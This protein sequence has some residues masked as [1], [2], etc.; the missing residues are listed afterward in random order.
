MSRGSE[1]LLT[2]K[3]TPKCEKFA[4]RRPYPNDP[5]HLSPNQS[6]IKGWWRQFSDAAENGR[7][8]LIS[9]PAAIDE[10]IEV[11][12]RP[13]FRD[14]ISP[15]DAD[16]L[17]NLLRRAELFNPAHIESICRDPSDDYL[18]ALAR[19]S[20]ADLLVTRDED[21]LVLKKHGKTEIV[22]VAEFLK[23]L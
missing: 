10:F 17:D 12:K 14:L 15:D 6:L 2:M 23:R 9:S 18:L 19:T 20:E 5:R 3:S 4:G 16:E 11:V 7:L 8:S 13:T 22:H 21:L 1:R